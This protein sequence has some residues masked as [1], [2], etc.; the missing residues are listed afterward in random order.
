MKILKSIY[1]DSL[2]NIWEIER[3]DLPNKRGTLITS[4]IAECEAIKLAFHEKTKKECINQIKKYEKS[5]KK[6]CLCGEHIDGYGHN[7]APLSTNE[8]DRCCGSCNFEKVIPARIQKIF[9]NHK[10]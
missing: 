8:Y 1:Q 7:P 9:Q 10:N 2:N 4:W 6:C 3:Y 5:G